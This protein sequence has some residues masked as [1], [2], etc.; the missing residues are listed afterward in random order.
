VTPY[1][2]LADIAERELELVTAGA[3]DRLSELHAQRH[4]I[5]ATLPATPPITAKPALERAAQLHARVTAEL[6]A[7]LRDTGAELRKL[8]QGRTAMR[9][10][11]PAVEPLKL[12]DRA[13]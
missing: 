11:A 6:E 9:G 5:V 10:Y 7:R 12:V 4:A 2:A 3:V 8:N 1:D 13:G